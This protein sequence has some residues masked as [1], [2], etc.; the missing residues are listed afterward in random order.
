MES[1]LVRIHQIEGVTVGEQQL[2]VL[3]DVISKLSAK[4]HAETLVHL[5]VIQLIP[6]MLLA[7]I[8]HGRC[9]LAKEE[10]PLYAVGETQPEVRDRETIR[11]QDR[12][13]EV[14]EAACAWSLTLPLVGRFKPIALGDMRRPEA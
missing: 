6:A 4:R 12:H 13:R 11:Q 3:I 10:I 7:I 5:L 8:E 1:P 9:F 14:A 2:P